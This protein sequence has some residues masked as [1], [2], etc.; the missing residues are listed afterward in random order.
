MRSDLDKHDRGTGFMCC[1]KYP[2]NIGSG[3]AWCFCVTASSSGLSLSEQNATDFIVHPR[4]QTI[5]FKEHT[6]PY[7]NLMCCAII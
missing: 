4:T 6:L 2:M 5:C 1:D 3:C 7:S